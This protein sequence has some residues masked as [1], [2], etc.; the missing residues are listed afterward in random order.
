[1]SGAPS[2]PPDSPPPHPGTLLRDHVL[3]VLGMPVSQA[4]R[5]LGVSRQTLHRIFS[6]EAAV[7]PAMA[8]RFARFCGADAGT[9]LRLQQEHDL[10]WAERQLGAAVTRIP[11]HDLPAPLPRHLRSLP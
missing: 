8:L 7:T 5:E 10:W 2:C 4:A 6:G 3:P 9:W 1:M 11:A